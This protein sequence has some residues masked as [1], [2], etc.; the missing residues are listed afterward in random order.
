MKINRL[1]W[2]NLNS[3]RGEFSLD[4]DETPLA[5]AGIFAII[6][7]TG[8]G[9]T[10]ILDAICV[11]LYGQTPRLAA[12]SSAELMTRN[13]SECFAEVEFTVEQGKYRSR[14]ARRRA[15]GRADGNLQP[16]VMEL[17]EIGGTEERIIEDQVRQVIERV[18]VLTGLDFAR[19]TRSVMLAQGSFASF[20]KAKENERAELLERMTGTR[21]YSFISMAAF[22]RA[23]DERGR[24]EELIAVN[25]HL[26]LLPPEQVAE[27]QAEAAALE[28]AI[29]AGEV[30]LLKVR[31]QEG[32]AARVVVLQ[33]SIAAAEEEL[34]A[35][36]AEQ[37]AAEPELQ[38]LARAEVAWPLLADLRSLDAVSQQ[39]EDLYLEAVALGGHR[40]RLQEELQTA[41]QAS[42]VLEQEAACFAERAT[43]RERTIAE[44]EKIDQQLGSQHEALAARQ[45]TITAIEQEM[46][47]LAAA[48]QGRQQ[49]FDRGSA[50]SEALDALLQRTAVDAGL[51]HDLSLI[52]ESL[53]ELA[54]HR[55][56]FAV[57]RREQERRTL[58]FKRLAQEIEGLRQQQEVSAE[59]RVALQGRLA[60]SEKDLAIHL[61]GSTSV[62]LEQEVM[63]NRGRVVRLSAVLALLDEGARLARELTVKEGHRLAIAKELAEAGGRR[64]LLYDERL[65]AEEVLTLLEEKEALAAQVAN[66]EADR[67]RLTAGAPCPLCGSVH[68][69]W[70]ANEIGSGVMDAAA[71]DQGRTAVVTQRQKVQSLIAEIGGLDGRVQEREAA[72][73]ALTAEID[74]GQAAESGLAAE[75]SVKAAAVD[76]LLPRQAPELKAA[77][78][79][80]I[81]AD[82]ARLVAIRQAQADNEGL[83]RQL[84]AAEK[85]GITGVVELEKARA[86]SLDHQ[87]ALARGQEEEEALCRQGVDLA[88]ALSPQ[89]GH[90]GVS[91][92]GP[93][94]EEAVSQLLR[95]RWQQYDLARQERV[96]LAAE[97]AEQRQTLAVAASQQ[98]G[99]K[100]RQDQEGVAAQGIAQ[101][102]A[103]LAEERFALLQ[104]ETVE[105][106]RRQLTA[107]R[108]GLASRQAES[109]QII[110]GLLAQLATQG[111]LLNKNGA[112][113]ARLTTERQ[114]QGQALDERV[115]AL[116]LADLL[117]LRQVL[118]PEA[119]LQALQERREAITLRRRR[120]E[121]RL[122]EARGQLTGLGEEASGLDRLALQAA[123]TLA[124][125]A[126]AKQ[127]QDLGALREKIRRQDE[128][129]A[130]HRE[131]IKVIERQSHELR[132]WQLL[133]DLIGSAD[134]KKFRRFAQGLTLDHLIGLANRQLIRLSDRY[135][136]R[137]Q[138]NE[139]LGLEIMDTYQ[140]DAIRPTGTLSGGE[141]FLVSL[142]LALGLANLSGQTRIDSLFLDEGF[143]SLDTDTLETALAALTALQETGKTIGII[144]HVDA[145]KERIPVQIRLRKL[146]GGF[147]TLAVTA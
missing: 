119:E 94:Q 50:R 28:A 93:G 33:E 65:R 39:V 25:A 130:E 100:E 102:V 106:A 47:Q 86:L 104:D 90:Y 58:E 6:G 131:R 67:R 29:T 133:S 27:L 76:L 51:G 107:E 32:L 52:A 15:R 5:E 18:E 24:L 113:T 114:S 99:L 123:V 85:A 7:P 147:S 70:S 121:D 20:L 144:S 2:K 97:L 128:L 134:G 3:L 103:S 31:E 136:L 38:R 74:S 122:Q 46:A 108:A 37:T 101:T 57:I 115:Q 71:R 135:L 30:A 69:P 140:A 55:E 124:S 60:A 48:C 120:L 89:L 98:H 82:Q 14:W 125:E 96:A 116:G 49:E 17:V 109:G 143:G 54:N 45:R 146:A 87:T 36:M 12:G 112:Q 72:L 88:A 92:P 78:E 59:A 79:K 9:K 16:T 22:S 95:Q 84:V 19:F 83:L 40:D 142:A 44:A 53:R 139:D 63:A 126:L 137:R 23:R 117:A 111:E 43:S 21:I 10:T 34:A 11:A 91:L 145:L 129:M 42:L 110:N 56:R 1:A 75:L 81:E 80:K 4:F 61:K 141:E 8:A 127:Q 13:C 73:G 118:L 64:Q 77:L 138:Q 41:R 66:Y 26:D 68:H 62:D 35:V 105:A 132:R